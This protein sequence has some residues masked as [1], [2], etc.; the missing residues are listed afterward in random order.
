MNDVKLVVKRFLT[1]AS[2][3]DRPSRRS[4]LPNADGASWLC[5]FTAQRN[6]GAGRSY[7]T[8]ALLNYR[9]RGQSAHAPSQTVACRSAIGSLSV[10][11][12]PVP[13]R[14]RMR[15]PATPFQPF[16]EFLQMSLRR[17]K[18]AVR[19][20][21]RGLASDGADQRRSRPRGIVCVKA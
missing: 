14:R 8:N 19:V 3:S 16:G 1:A 20:A 15:Q 2:R 18:A 12:L 17:L 10:N 21:Q 4:G 5:A 13:F 6:K 11:S 9:S 7:L